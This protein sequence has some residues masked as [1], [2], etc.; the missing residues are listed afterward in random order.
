MFYNIQSTLPTEYSPRTIRSRKKSKTNIHIVPAPFLPSSFARSLTV[1]F[2]ARRPGYSN[3]EK[4][5]ET[6]PPGSLPIYAPAQMGREGWSNLSRLLHVRCPPSVVYRHLTGAHNALKDA[7]HRRLWFARC[8]FVSFVPYTGTPETNAAL[9]ATAVCRPSSTAVAAYSSVTVSWYRITGALG[10]SA[11][12]PL[13]AIA[14]AV[15]CPA[16]F[17]PHWNPIDWYSSSTVTVSAPSA[18]VAIS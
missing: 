15:S 7:S 16:N 3:R 14:S 12:Y 4:K 17:S 18:L 9:P 13:N 2:A 11:R 8:L 5:T 1:S 10:S 6:N